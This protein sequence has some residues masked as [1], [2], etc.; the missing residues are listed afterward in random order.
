[1]VD[2]L[3]N[4]SSQVGLRPGLANPRGAP[5][6]V[7]TS[8]AET[9][10]QTVFPSPM[11]ETCYPQ[12]RSMRIPSPKARRR[13]NTVWKSKDSPSHPNPVV[14]G[15]SRCRFCFRA[16]FIETEENDCLTVQHYNQHGLPTVLFLAARTW[17]PTLRCMEGEGIQTATTVAGARV[18]RLRNMV[19][20]LG[21]CGMRQQHSV[22]LLLTSRARSK[23]KHSIHVLTSVAWH[24]CRRLKVV[25]PRAVIQLIDKRH[26]PRIFMGLGFLRLE[27][28]ETRHCWS[29]PGEA[30]A[31]AV[32][33]H[34]RGQGFTSVLLPS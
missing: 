32:R 28:T 4:N 26:V 19:W 6:Q 1:M 16:S 3:A 18:M 30:R 20:R 23:R 10:G 25:M 17:T 31:L 24:A 29:C 11:Q 7:P 2:C 12:V 15:P 9:P 34:D 8:V 5:F 27:S 33:D 21:A 22:R 14:K 13:T